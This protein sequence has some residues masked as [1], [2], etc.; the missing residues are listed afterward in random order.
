[1]KLS[2]LIHE[3]E[4]LLCR[5]DMDIEIESICHS[6][7]E[8]DNCSLLVIP[9]SNKIPTYY[10]IR[11]RAIL[12]DEN[13]IIDED[14]PCV[15]VENVRR[16]IAYAYSRFHRV[17]HP[18]LRLIGI[19]GTN[20]KTST[21]IF[22]KRG[23]EASGMKVGLIGTGQILVGD[24]RIT[25]DNYSMTSPDPWVLYPVLSKMEK[26]GCDAV[27]MEVSSHALAL[28]KVAPL[29]FDYAV[30]TNM[31][32]EHLDF[33]H[34]MEGYYEAKRKLFSRCT[35]A[36]INIDDY[37]GRRLTREIT[38]RK[39]TAGALWRGD[40][41]VNNID[42]KGFD[43]VDYLYHGKNFTFKMN[44][45]SAGVF[46]IYNSMLAVA[47]CTDLGVKPCEVK[48]AISDLPV[49]SG[50]YEII[51]D[52]IT[53][54]IDY[55]HTDTAFENILK[56]LKQAKRGTQQL[57]VVFGCGG[58]R[59]KQK[60]PRMAA[61]AEKYADEIYVTSDNS[62]S[63]EPSS[64][65]ADIVKGFKKSSYKVIEDRMSAIREAVKNAKRDSIVA[66]LG[67]G[68]EKYNIDKFGYH[69]FNEK[70]II[71]AALK[72]RRHDSR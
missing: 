11:P 46:N 59:D 2:E 38:S 31:S 43:G 41:Y 13:A 35:T 16:A 20:G 47:V 55:A 51:K 57:S 64:I 26:D 21:S 6:A 30:F 69:Y 40:V 17:Q 53:V 33:H 12:C 56:N 61:V 72:E 18:K 70:E 60:R 4:Y 52:E 14:I 62:R 49:I 22:I 34:D 39:I 71:T 19:T 10:N 1:M 44:L 42:N 66:I 54:I 25:D 23:L 29:W 63:E 7:T 32:M 48:R 3:G 8:L 15:R 68:A 45:S 65:I 28:E 36:V 5:A 50:R 9:N 24:E 27:I 37:Y 58:D 67:K